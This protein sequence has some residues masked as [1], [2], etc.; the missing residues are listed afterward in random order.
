MRNNAGEIRVWTAYVWN[1]TVSMTG[2]CCGR[3]KDAL[4][5]RRGHPSVH[6]CRVRASTDRQRQENTV[7]S[8][9]LVNLGEACFWLR[10]TRSSF[11]RDG[12]QVLRVK[13]SYVCDL[14][15]YTFRR[16][17]N[18]HKSVRRHTHTQRL[19]F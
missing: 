9:Q 15:L 17:T 13:L 10:K 14:F 1:R 7:K 11:L 19:S 2:L 5:L 18:V 3:R 16:N 8:P 6:T 12:V 4:V